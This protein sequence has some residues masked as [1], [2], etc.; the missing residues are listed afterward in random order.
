MYEGTYGLRSLYQ[1]CIDAYGTPN[2]S[3]IDDFGNT[4]YN[5]FIGN[6]KITLGPMEGNVLVDYEPISM[7][8]P[9][10]HT[11]DC[12]YGTCSA[13]DK[14]TGLKCGGCCKEREPTCYKHR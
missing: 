8:A 3:Y 5:W 4:N 13:I 14:T 11:T 12:F 7:P 1:K 9:K 10:V 6:T 2:K